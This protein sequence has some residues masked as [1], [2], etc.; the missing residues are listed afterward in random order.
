MFYL[1]GLDVFTSSEVQQSL[2]VLEK[3]T[4]ASK[5]VTFFMRTRGD[6][7]L[8]TRPLNNRMEVVP[9]ESNGGLHWTM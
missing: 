6:F 9:E 5:W 8:F 4:L 3:L 1:F 7:I 2:E